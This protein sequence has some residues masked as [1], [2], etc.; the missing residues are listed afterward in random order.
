MTR[1]SKSTRG[2]NPKIDNLNPFCPDSLVLAT[3][4]FHPIQVP[5][6]I[7]MGMLREALAP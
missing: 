2:S 1:L 3:S 5:R 6:R 4:I 7:Y